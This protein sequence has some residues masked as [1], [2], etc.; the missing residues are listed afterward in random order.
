MVA[1]PC[2][3]TSKRMGAS[4]LSR[5]FLESHDITQEAGNPIYSLAAFKPVH[6]QTQSCSENHLFTQL[7]QIFVLQN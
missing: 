1:R 5:Q 3:A 2:T 7:Y 6:V 4:V